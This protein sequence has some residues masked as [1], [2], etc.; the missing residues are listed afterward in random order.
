M[1][2]QSSDETSS[3]Q[4]EK[5]YESPANGDPSA[6]VPA[7]E[8]ESP[9]PSRAQASHDSRPL[10]PLP[11]PPVIQ[12][13]KA[14]VPRITR[15]SRPPTILRG[16]GYARNPQPRLDPPVLD[17]LGL[18]EI[19]PDAESAIQLE[20]FA[21][22][23][24]FRERSAGVRPLEGRSA[25]EAWGWRM[26]IAAF[27]AV[28]KGGIAEGRDL[29]SLK[30][31]E[32][33]LHDCVSDAVEVAAKRAGI[34][35]W[36]PRLEEQL[37]DSQKSAEYEAAWRRFLQPVAADSDNDHVVEAERK[38]TSIAT[39]LPPANRGKGGRRPGARV[40]SEKLKALRSQMKNHDGSVGIS[41]EALAEACGL[42]VDTISRGEAGNRW[43]DA[44]FEAVAKGL[45]NLT[46][47]MVKPD[48]LKKKQR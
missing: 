43:D 30:Q 12:G 8:S 6:P 26:F 37:R 41:H 23:S 36:R 45:T 13:G 11:A 38:P 28:C 32:V 5:P 15:A 19:P 3:S 47:R 27:R 29:R 14:S 18:P 31:I 9:H 20:Q 22:D 40:D 21:A 42:S 7:V 39:P 34:H 35:D 25:L 44:S 2:S 48:D 17:Y 10:P 16:S 4:A 46:K 1:S 33:D 24:E